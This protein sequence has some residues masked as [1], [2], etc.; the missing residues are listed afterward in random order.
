MLSDGAARTAGEWVTF[1]ASGYSARSNG[2]LDGMRQ[3]I[4]RGGQ[5][6]SKDFYDQ[7]YQRRILWGAIGGGAGS[8]L[9]LPREITWHPILQQLIFTPIVELSKLRTPAS[10]LYA[11]LALPPLRPNTVRPLVPDSTAFMT[12]NT[13]SF[14]LI[15]SFAPPACP[16]RFGVSIPTGE[17]G[18]PR[19]AQHP[20]GIM[21]DWM[22]DVT[23]MGVGVGAVG[24]EVYSR[25]MA[26]TELP[27]F[28]GSIPPAP[29][30][31]PL[32]ATN[33]TWPATANFSKRGT[34]IVCQA[35]CDAD[36]DCKSWSYY[37][38]QAGV[39]RCVRYGGFP[40]P[41]PRPGSNMTC[42]VKNPTTA[43]HY[44]DP[45]TTGELQVL[46]NLD[47]A[48]EM[49]IFSD[50]EVLEIYW[51]GGRVAM[52]TKGIDWGAGVVAG[53]QVSL[54]N[55]RGACPVQVLNVTVWRMGSI[56]QSKS[57][58]LKRRDELHGQRKIKVD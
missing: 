16:T 14:E 56:W 9:T 25:W 12:F 31:T 52:T 10:P 55:L 3:P 43:P 11:D 8:G 40:P 27:R 6:A 33:V 58:V 4:D 7:P 35:G 38:Q 23:T 46:R 20:R 34:A 54:F 32:N 53:D 1:N 29:Y 47:K 50:G 57:E 19:R 22:P 18:P 30:D 13:S 51:Q 26:D 28:G 15:A 41:T 44:A 45:E 24:P 39:A 37:P 5:Y 48:I 21:V 17:P 42:G 49:R 2:Q 36:A